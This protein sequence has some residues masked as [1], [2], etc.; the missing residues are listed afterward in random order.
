MTADELDRV[1]AGIE[2]TS[3]RLDSLLKRFHRKYPSRMQSLSELLDSGDARDFGF[4]DR[5]P[6]I[7]GARFR[8]R[9]GGVIERFRS[10]EYGATP[11][12]SSID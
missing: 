2:A 12:L 6:P 9:M 5:V 1:S 10:G 8:A 3:Q 7:I 11:S 4:P